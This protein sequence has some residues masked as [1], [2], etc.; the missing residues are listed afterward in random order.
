MN[1]K[2]EIRKFLIAAELGAALVCCAGLLAAA[3]ANQV[4]AEWRETDSAGDERIAE[5]QGGEKPLTPLQLEAKAILDIQREAMNR[6][7]E[8]ATM[9]LEPIP[10]EAV[11][12]AEDAMKQFDS[13]GVIV[14]P[15]GTELRMVK[16]EAG[17]FTMGETDEGI[18]KEL[19]DNEMPHEVTLKHVFWLGR[20]EVTQAQWKA[21]MSNRT[22]SGFTGDDLPVEVVS[23][24]DIQIFCGR[25]N[26]MYAG[27]LPAGYRFDLP[28]EAQW[29]YAARGG[30]KGKGFKYS[31]SDDL[32][33]VAWHD[34]N[35]GQTTH[36]VGTKQPNELGLYDMTGNV[37]E[38]CRD[39]YEKDYAGDPEFLR[40][41][42][43]DRRVC[44]GGGW[45]YTD[46]LIARIAFRDPSGSDSRDIFTGFR[47]A[48]VPTEPV[49]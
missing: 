4:M 35:S 38:W 42:Q 18:D 10:A 8:L 31:G 43:G 25:L 44:H 16:V 19:F 33:A 9:P 47:L 23:W 36:P 27:K 22:P 40:G 48:L 17:T 39:W 46:E 41:N 34:G 1:R 24:D 49:E 12:L 20:T 2:P 45:G 6:A 30:K 15:G 37:T 21:V 5:E 26:G 13:T 29:E 3:R 11:K 32:D 7:K 28:T 14:L